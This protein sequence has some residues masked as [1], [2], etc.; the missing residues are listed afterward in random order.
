MLDGKTNNSSATVHLAG[1]PILVST[2]TRSFSLSLPGTGGHL[3]QVPARTA[4][5]T[6]TCFTFEKDVE[7]D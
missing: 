5:T 4:R 7:F 1:Y 2:C 3:V 6:C